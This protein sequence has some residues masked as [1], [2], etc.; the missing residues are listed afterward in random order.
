MAR[1]HRVTRVN[2]RKSTRASRPRKT[3]LRKMFTLLDDDDDDDELLIRG[4]MQRSVTLH[5]MAMPTVLHIKTGPKIRKKYKAY[6]ES[7][8]FHCKAASLSPMGLLHMSKRKTKSVF[9]VDKK[10]FDLLYSKIFPDKLEWE[11][12]E[13]RNN[14]AVCHA[15]ALRIFL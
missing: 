10:T 12:K 2:M 8:K 6:D 11:S 15:E 5:S 3:S 7:R 13:G 9:R 14:I 4:M 1:T